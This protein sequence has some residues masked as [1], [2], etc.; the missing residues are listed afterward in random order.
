MTSFEPWWE[1]FHG[2]KWRK[3][4][5]SMI[6][7]IKTSGGPSDDLEPSQRQSE[8]QLDWHEYEIMLPFKFPTGLK[9]ISCISSR[10]RRPRERLIMLPLIF[11]SMS[12]SLH[13]TRVAALAK[14]D[15]LHLIV[16]LGAEPQTGNR[17]IQASNF[18]VLR[19]LQ[20]LNFK[21]RIKKPQQLGGY[22]HK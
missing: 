16:T 22:R 11:I 3:T 1:Q 15:D 13:I 20:F 14:L 4:V 21:V 18:N 5:N 7:N 6:F 12:I 10:S 8:R 2:R 17:M 9:A 19:N